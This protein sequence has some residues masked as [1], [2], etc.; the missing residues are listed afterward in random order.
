M[1]EEK[2]TSKG[3]SLVSSQYDIML[4]S[5]EKYSEPNARLGFRVLVEVVER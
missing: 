5:K 4:I 2:G 1:V 3:G